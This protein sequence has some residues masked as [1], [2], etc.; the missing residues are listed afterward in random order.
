MSSATYTPDRWTVLAITNAAG[1]RHF[2]ILASWYGGFL[3]SDSWRMSSGISKIEPGPDH[4]RVHN[5]TTGSVYICVKGA[6][7]T[8]A[9]VSRVL[10]SYQEQARAAGATIKELDSI[11]D[12]AL[13]VD[14]ELV[15]R[16]R[17][18]VAGVRVD[19]DERL[20][21]EGADQHDGDAP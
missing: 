16:L 10:A 7:G 21:P 17:E 3:G 4:Y 12:V 2:R 11:E 1:E 13:P 20:P 8:S 6:Q 9:F 15:Q 19:L 18:S 5:D 14:P